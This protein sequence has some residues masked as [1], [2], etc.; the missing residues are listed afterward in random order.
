MRY[1]FLDTETGGLVPAAADVLELAWQL[2]DESFDVLSDGRHYLPMTMPASEKAQ[3]INGLT[4][5]FLEGKTSLP[6]KAY[7]E[8]LQALRQADYIVG[9]FIIFDV[10]ML[11]ADANRR[12]HYS[13][14]AEEIGRYLERKKRIDTKKDYI[15]LNPRWKNRAHPGPYLE[16]LCSF[17]Q[18]SV[19]RGEFHS[20]MGDTNATRLCLKQIKYMYDDTIVG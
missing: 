18:V 16:E 20:A 12:L 11:K 5:E 4:E 15:F 14:E 17:L 19:P 6:E 1:L 7:G 13:V 9:H 8:F 3:K 2:T 10:E